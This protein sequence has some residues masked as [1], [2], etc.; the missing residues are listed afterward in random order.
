MKQNHF[1]LDISI[2]YAPKKEN[3]KNFLHIVKIDII[4]YI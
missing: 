4:S 2:T 1:Y 3:V